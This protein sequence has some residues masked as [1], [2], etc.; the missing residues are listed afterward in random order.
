MMGRLLKLVVIAGL[1]AILASWLSQQEGMSRLDWLGYRIEVQTSWLAAVFLIFCVVLIF[2]YRFWRALRHWPS[3]I[4]SGWRMRRR[5]RGERALALGMV[6][7]AA[8]DGKA[9]RKQAK[10]SEKLL[11]RGMLPDLLAAQAAH[12]NGDTKAAQR[13]FTDLSKEEDTAYYGQ[14]GLMNLHHGFQDDKNSKKAAQKALALNPKAGA[15]AGHLRG[16]A[17]QDADWKTAYELGR[18]LKQSADQRDQ[19]PASLA[20]QQGVI[21][22]LQAREMAAEKGTAGEEMTWLEKAVA[23]A[24][25][26]LAAAQELAR[27]EEKYGRNKKAI[28]ILEKTFQLAP[29]AM[30]LDDLQRLTGDNDGQFIARLIKLAKSSKQRVEAAYVIARRALQAGIWASASAQLAEI[31]TSEQRSDYFEMMAE[32]ARHKEDETAQFEAMQQATRAPRGPAWQCH[33]CELILPQFE[34]VCP[35]CAEVGQISWT[36]SK[37]RTLILPDEQPQDQK[38][39]DRNQAVISLPND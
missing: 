23:D 26:L 14:I 20:Y 19:Q 5:Q 29:H 25:D 11:G 13:Y 4:T 2:I 18:I 36:R 8:G 24:P 15:P 35:A 31:P 32:L 12:A 28:T 38:P 7:L 3:L 1:T 37:A 34:P 6:A 10:R 17:L 22:L 21:A 30:V 9:A 39:K 33:S 27:A 16:Y